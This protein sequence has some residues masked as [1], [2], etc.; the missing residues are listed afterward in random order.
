MEKAGL[1]IHTN[2]IHSGKQQSSLLP[3]EVLLQYCLGRKGNL[4]VFDLGRSKDDPRSV[5]K[6]L[7]KQ[8]AIQ[9][10]MELF[11]KDH[12]G[13]EFCYLVELEG[14]L[15]SVFMRNAAVPPRVFKLDETNVS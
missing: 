6:I 9:R 1:C 12:E 3:W 15:V 13:R 11:D 14:K 10:E 5:W 2:A 8:E 7:D 4:G